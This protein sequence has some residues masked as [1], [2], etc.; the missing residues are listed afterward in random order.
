MVSVPKLFNLPAVSSNRI[1]FWVCTP[2]LPY[3]FVPCGA[4]FIY[5]FIEHPWVDDFDYDLCLSTGRISEWHSLWG[6]ILPA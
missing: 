4:Y 6:L 3:S 5:L 1:S 2:F